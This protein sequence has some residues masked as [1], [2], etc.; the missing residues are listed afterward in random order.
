MISLFGLIMVLGIIVDDAIVIGEA[1]YV[2]RKR[3]EPPLK[4]AVEGV[5][6]VG[7]PVVAAVTTTIVAFLPLVFVGGVMGKF[8][9]ILPV[10][11]VAC[12]AV[13]LVEGLIL[14]PAHL[15]HLPDPNVPPKGRHPLRKMGLAFHRMTSHGL[16][17]FVEHLYAPFLLKTLKW[18]YISLSV[19]ISMLLVP[20]G[21]MQGG[22]LKCEVFSS[23]DGDIITATV[24]FPSG[25]PV[26]VTR[27]A[28]R[29]LE[30]ALK[31]LNARI[32]T[33]SGEPLM[34]GYHSLVG[35]TLDDFPSYG[36]F[37]GSVRVDLLES[38]KRGVHSKDLMV[39]WEKEVGEIP[40]CGP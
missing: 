27:D 5:L 12:L 19:A 21:F 11:V 10:V 32:K 8:I 28:V 31:R 25:T 36:T 26:D 13:S 35:Q 15:I 29:Q 6:E 20:V 17:W 23:I 39:E 3:G 16:E 14:L 4:A 24:E 34:N 9:Y 2:H 40:A 33:A 18:R 22:I 7:I 1:I 37:L 38:V 30:K